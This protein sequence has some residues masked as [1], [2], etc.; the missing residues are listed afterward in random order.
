M[1]TERQRGRR[2]ARV[3]PLPPAPRD[4]RLM[5]RA[6]LRAYLQSPKYFPYKADL[7]EFARRYKIPVNARTPREEIVRLCLRMIYDIPRGFTILRF[8]AE[9]HDPFIIDHSRPV[10]H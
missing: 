9:K 4:P 10:L 2:V 3:H 8:L 6:E 7:L 1:Y 5:D